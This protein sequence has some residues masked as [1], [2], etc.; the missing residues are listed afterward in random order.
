[1]NSPSRNA[2]NSVP[3]LVTIAIN[4]F[5]YESYLA[6]AIDSALNQDYPNLE[7]ILVDDGSTDQSRS[8]MNR[9]Q[10][11][12][13]AIYKENDGQGSTFNAA[14]AAS[15]GQILCFLDADDVFLP[16]K[17]STI[18]RVFADNPEVGLV[19]HRLQR[20]DATNKPLGTPRPR[21]VLCGDIRRRVERSGGWWPRP[22][23]SGLCAS[24][25]FLKKILPMPCKPY[26][27]CADAYIGGLAPFL[28]PVKGIAEPLALYRIHG[29]NYYNFRGMTPRAESERRMERLISEF[30]QLGTALQ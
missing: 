30:D 5:N 7:V 4:N 19:Y 26:R 24:R 28:G 18:A 13:T 17:V 22:T 11:R 16:N 8:I 9:Y 3:L 29:A 10:T 1:M 12:V 6:E 21:S 27:L 2:G 23:T 25:A 15:K 14:F 20:V